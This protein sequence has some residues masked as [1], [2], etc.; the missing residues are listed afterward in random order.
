MTTVPGSSLLAPPL[1]N[2]L[3][4]RIVIEHRTT[5]SE[6]E[7]IMSDALAF[8]AACARNSGTPLSPSPRVDLG[9]HT[10]LLHTQD[11]EQFCDR[12]A[13]R[14]LHHVPTDDQ[15]DNAHDGLDRTVR[16]IQDAGFTVEPSLWASAS[17]QCT[18][19]HGGCHDDPPPDKIA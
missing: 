7:A 19:C 11:Y 18:G 1:F 6:A 17:A 4:R 8:L 14:F 3:A 10:F 12:L 13:G 2:R 16:A 9:W 15:H 5:L